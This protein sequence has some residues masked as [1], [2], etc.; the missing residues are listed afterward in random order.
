[1]DSD[2]VLLQH[3]RIHLSGR[4]GNTSLMEGGGGGG[5]VAGIIKVQAQQPQ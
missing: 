4:M 1:M 3:L 2:T 5:E